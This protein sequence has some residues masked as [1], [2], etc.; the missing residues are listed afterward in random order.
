MEG[1]DMSTRTWQAGT[2]SAWMAP[3][4]AEVVI[5]LPTAT[6]VDEERLNR[7]FAM[8]CDL[9]SRWPYFMRLSQDSLHI[10]NTGPQDKELYCCVVIPIEHINAS[11]GAPPWPMALGHRDPRAPGCDHSGGVVHVTLAYGL[12]WSSWEQRHA[13]VLRARM[14]LAA[15]PSAG[16]FAQFAT[17]SRRGSSLNLLAG[18]EFYCLCATLRQELQATGMTDVVVPDHDVFHITWAT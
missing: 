3:A 12:Q 6:P 1:E 11:A 7:H 4:P 15:S 17:G 13:A 8:M 10:A 18:S 14:M 5:T 9:S 2:H 16:I